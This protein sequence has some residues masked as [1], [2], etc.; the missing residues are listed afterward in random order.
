V[1]DEEFYFRMPYDTL[2]LLLYAWERDVTVEEVSAAMG[3]TEEQIRRAFR[4][5][6]SKSKATRHLRMLP[7]TL[8]MRM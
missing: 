6:A 8:D 2:D 5:F 7:P 1:T 4:D 3:L